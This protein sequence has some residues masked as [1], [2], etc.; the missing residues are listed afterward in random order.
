MQ[1]LTSQLISFSHITPPCFP[2]CSSLLSHFLPVPPVFLFFFFY[3][4]VSTIL[5][6]S[7]VPQVG[8]NS[9]TF[10]FS[11]SYRLFSVRC[12]GAKKEGSDLDDVFFDLFW[13]HHWSK[14]PPSYHFF[15][16]FLLFLM[17]FPPRLTSHLAEQFLGTL[18]SIGDDA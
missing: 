17:F 3:F 13:S 9:S 11:Q 8:L 6:P 1:Y 2:S 5:L 10:T 7:T 12:A 18:P 15:L 14:G 16:I 4:F